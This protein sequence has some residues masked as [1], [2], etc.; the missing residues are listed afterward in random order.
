MG[1]PIRLEPLYTPTFMI[2]ANQDVG[3]NGLDLGIE[4]QQ[5]VPV[6]PVPPKVDHPS[7]QRVLEA[8]AVC[9]GEGWAFHVNDERGVG[10]VRRL[11]LFHCSYI[12]S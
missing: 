7:H 1:K 3:P 6:L 11:V 8:A 10:G 4:T 5:L 2:D 9:L 12:N